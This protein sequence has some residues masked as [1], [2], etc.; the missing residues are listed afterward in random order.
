VAEK[1]QRAIALQY[2]IVNR[3]AAPRILAK[4]QGDLAQR[5]LDVAKSKGIPLYRDPELVEVLGQLDI[6]AQIQPELYHAVAEVLIFI[7]KMNRKKRAAVVD[8]L[9]SQAAKLRL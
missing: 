3:S 6:G 8:Q 7:Y 5:I 2:D 4:G 1:R 9:K